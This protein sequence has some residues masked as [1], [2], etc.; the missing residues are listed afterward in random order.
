MKKSKHVDLS[1]IDYCDLLNQFLPWVEK[2]KT[3]LKIS[4][5]LWHKVYGWSRP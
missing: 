5:E 4:D 3:I 2:N 1:K